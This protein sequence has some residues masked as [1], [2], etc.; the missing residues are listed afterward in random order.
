MGLVLDYLRADRRLLEDFLGVV[1]Q[2]NLNLPSRDAGAPFF[3]VQRTTNRSV[4]QYVTKRTRTAAYIVAVDA[5]KP[6][7]GRG[8]VDRILQEVANIG[9]KRIITED[10]YW[11][12]AQVQQGRVTDTV[13]REIITGIVDDAAD[14]LEGVAWTMEWMRWRALAYGTLVYD[15]YGVSLNIS[16]GIPAGNILTPLAGGA[17]WSAAATA[18]PITDLQAMVTQWKTANNALDPAAAGG[19]FIMSQKSVNYMLAAQ[20][21]RNLITGSANLAIPKAQ[22]DALLTIYGLPPIQINDESITFLNI[23]GTFLV[24]RKLPED[25][26]VLAPADGSIGSLLVGPTIEALTPGLFTRDAQ[27]AEPG[28]HAEVYEISRD[29][30]WDGIKA[31]GA[32]FPL[33]ALPERIVHL[34]VW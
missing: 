31:V 12:L 33:V 29:P 6:T 10:D 21:V 22:L 18:T 20:S 32:A 1:D 17:L 25:L 28:L 8:Q 27:T 26:V 7:M 19:R 2:A 5:E 9:A 14:L 15:R 16:F 3:P 11:T 30:V 34:D 24:Q 13:A 4:I 23:D